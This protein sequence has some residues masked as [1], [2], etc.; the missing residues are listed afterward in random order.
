MNETGSLIYLIDDDPM[1]SSTLQRMLTGRS[2][3]VRRWMTA[4]AALEKVSNDRPALIVVEACLPAMNGYEFL[5]KLREL[6][7]SGSPSVILISRA[8][9]TPD[10]K[11]RALSLG[12]NDFLCKP[13]S[14]DE[15]L[16]RVRAVLR[17]RSL[18]SVVFR[19]AL[20]CGDLR[21]DPARME[22]SVRGETLRLSPARFRVLDLLVRHRGRA[23]TFRQIMELA[24]LRSQGDTTGQCVRWHIHSL[25][26]RLGSYATCLRTWRNIG[27]IWVDEEPPP[28]QTVSNPAHV[29]KTT[30]NRR[31]KTT[32]EP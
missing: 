13:I 1:D 16:E 26:K 5:K 22:C 4:E 15:F 27:Y 8:Y 9:T 18:P 28:S 6:P 30:A 32:N 31:R 2:F 29:Q 24:E 7:E 21:L 11:A 3:R 23:F 20:V 17:R 14:Y 10:D 12:A 19:S 25:R